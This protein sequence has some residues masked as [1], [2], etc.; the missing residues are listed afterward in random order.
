MRRPGPGGSTGSESTAALR[1]A[2]LIYAL[3]VAIATLLPSSLAVG[4]GIGAGSGPAKQVVNEALGYLA[5]AIAAAL[6]IVIPW[7]LRLAKRLGVSWPLFLCALGYVVGVAYLASEDLRRATYE[8]IVYD[9]PD[10]PKQAFGEI[11][12]L[13][14]AGYAGLGLLAG[15]A[16]R[17]R[18][19]PV[20][21]GGVVLA[22][23]LL[24]E[25]LQDLVPGREPTPRDLTSN[26]L[27]VLIGY[28]G[29]GLLAL[30]SAG[31]GPDHRSGR[32]RGR[33]GRGRSGARRRRHR[34]AGAEAPR[35]TSR[36]SGAG[37]GSERG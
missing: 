25:I 35:R 19:H 5:A 21:T 12:P 9:L 24:L 13:H 2:S 10:W 14:V 36:R 11:D 18:L 26:A 17:E 22:F 23:G 6:L 31:P 29:I 7:R 15:L 32:G 30:L 20:P 16:W 8:L 37:R 3:V 33:D 1:W 28:V 4:L 27:G 34:G